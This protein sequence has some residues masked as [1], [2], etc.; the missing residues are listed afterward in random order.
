MKS[1][2]NAPSSVV[3][4]GGALLLAGS[5][6]IGNLLPVL[7]VGWPANISGL[8]QSIAAS[9][10]AGAND[11]DARQGD[12]RERLTNSVDAGR[13]SDDDMHKIKQELEKVA[14]D[15]A[16]Y[17]AKNSELSGFQTGHLRS[18]L[19]RIGKELDAA[20]GD[21]RGAAVDVVAESSRINAQLN[22]SLGAKTLT[23]QE[24]DV[25]KTDLAAINARIASAKG[26]NGQI[27]TNDQVRIALEL[28]NLNQRLKASGPNKQV[29]LTS[30]DKR[31]NE[32]RQM[33]RQGV[34]TGH[35]TE[36]EVDDLRQ[37]LYNYDAK[38]ARLSKLGRPLTSD[39]QMA[40]A[41]ELERFGA[42][43]RARMDNGVDTVITERTIGYRKAALDQSFANDLF[44]GDISM[45]E[46]RQFK[47]DLDKISTEEASER[48]ASG[49]HLTMPQI[50]AILLNVEI[51][52]GKFSRL[53]FNRARVW[54]GVD[55]MVAD[56]R[57]KIA[58]VY[59][60]KKLTEEEN[61]A[62]QSHIADVLVAK[63]NE[64][65]AGGFVTTEAALKLAAEITVLSQQ[66]MKK[67]SE[68]GAVPSTKQAPT[69]S[70]MPV[71]DE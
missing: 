57:Q 44:S 15:E 37:Q 67:L 18:E 63:S 69:T 9:D 45:A 62:M 71:N 8:S 52:K 10:V 50:E 53:T 11:V 5:I 34:V 46:A 20:L 64:R 3:R 35:L 43:I 56:L 6:L 51:L 25:F 60:A 28:D 59:A 49:N 29:D 32:L 19:E 26:S 33:I 4:C 22:S 24:Y 38:E 17:K 36:D 2:F 58:D 7:A 27:A 40:I 13:V 39:E 1:V 14:E 41:L 42:E 54:I 70:A 55:G 65:N 31:K 68:V 48:K 16:G 12:L 66:V 61:D 30:I 47:T 21:H 23:Q